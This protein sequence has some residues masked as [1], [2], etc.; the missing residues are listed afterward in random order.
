MNSIFKRGQLKQV[1]QDHVQSGFE[2][3][4][5]WRLHSLS[6]Q[7]IPVFDHP[8]SNKVFS[9]GQVEFYVFQ[10]VPVPSCPVSGH[11][12]EESLSLFFI[13]S[14]EVSLHLQIEEF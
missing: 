8:Q 7:P 2:C 13:L 10:F 14:Y 1:T 3:L 11:Y 4:C 9:C 12:G 6:E 5:G